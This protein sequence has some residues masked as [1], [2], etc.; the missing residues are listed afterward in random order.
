M[1]G[2]SRRIQVT[3]GLEKKFF[4]S[5]AGACRIALAKQKRTI[6]ASRTGY[7][8]RSATHRR[9]LTNKNAAWH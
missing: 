2:A 3:Q 9:L 6:P 4:L 1:E 8:D 5:N 7:T